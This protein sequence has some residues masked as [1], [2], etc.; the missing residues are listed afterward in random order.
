MW[1]E[2]RERETERRS[3]REER[4]T[5]TPNT[6]AL[7]RTTL[8]ITI[9]CLCR[10]P[11][12]CFQGA[13]RFSTHKKNLPNGQTLWSVFQD[14]SNETRKTHARG[15]TCTSRERSHSRVPLERERLQGP[16]MPASI[17]VPLEFDR[18]FVFWPEGPCFSTDGDCSSDASQSISSSSWESGAVDVTP[19]MGLMLPRP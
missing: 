3:K 13:C 6:Y 18:S 17:G 2:R 9:G 4:E 14:G 11:S 5:E 15:D 7:A 12:R 8:K 10:G 16:S 19:D 1:E